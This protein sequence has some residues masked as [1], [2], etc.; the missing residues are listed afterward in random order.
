M[1]LLRRDFLK[2]LVTVPFLGVFISGFKRNIEREVGSKI[3]DYNKR[4]KISGLNAPL[5]KLIP[6]T[7][8]DGKRIR[9]GLVGCGWRGQALLEKFGYIHTD[10]LEKH[11]SNGVPS[12]WLQ[13]LMEQEDLNVEIAGICDVFDV[14]T[15][16]GVDISSNNIYPGNKHNLKTTEIF[17]S[18]RD[19]V[20][21]D[22]IDAI[23]IATPDHTHADI[24][25]AAANAG[26]HVYLEKPMT[27]SIEEAI[28]LRDTI[29]KA[30]V[31]FQVGHQNRQQMSYKVGRELYQRGFLGEVTQ[32]ETFT[33]RN[34]IN[35]AWIRDDVRDHKLGN[36]HNINWEEFL[37]DAPRVEFDRKRFFS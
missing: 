24:A 23:L 35:G 2:G 4:L 1:S 16:R 8:K 30:G 12:N 17:Q 21:S 6:P 25:I 3:I 14:H 31:V 33:N 13:N 27:H 28:A 34:T 29:R 32:V 20:K 15:Q 5:E 18:Y 26:K 7:G 19:M 22:N 36:E 9:I 10:V 37:H 11:L